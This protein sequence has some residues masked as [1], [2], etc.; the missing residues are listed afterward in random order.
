MR[1]LPQAPRDPAMY[2]SAASTLSGFADNGEWRTL[3][4][5][6]FAGRKLEP[7]TGLGRDLA[8]EEDR[9]DFLP[10]VPPVFSVNWDAVEGV[11]VW[12]GV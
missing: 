3:A 7:S 11:C 6:G 4:G 10:A 8:G 9:T 1:N 2:V 12:G 5:Q